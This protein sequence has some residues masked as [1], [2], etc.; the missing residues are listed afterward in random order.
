[1]FYSVEPDTG[2]QVATVEYVDF[3]CGAKKMTRNLV[4]GAFITAGTISDLL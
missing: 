4:D 3:R 2:I 1:M